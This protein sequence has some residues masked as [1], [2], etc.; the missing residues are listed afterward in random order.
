MK[1]DESGWMN[2]PKIMTKEKEKTMINKWR[3]LIYLFI[4][5]SRPKNWESGRN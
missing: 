4:Y 5:F 1:V 3:R 2:V